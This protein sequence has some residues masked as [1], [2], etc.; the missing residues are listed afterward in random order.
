[1][2]YWMFIFDHQKWYDL[3]EKN[4]S[5]KTQ[6]E[7][8]AEGKPNLAIGLIYFL[9]GLVFELSYIPFMIAM[10]RKEFFQYSCYKFMFMMGIYDMFILPCNGI[11]TGIQVMKGEHFCHNPKL[12]YL[13]GV[14]GV[15]GFYG[16][17]TLCV[18]LGFDR[19]LEM[20]FPR[21][22]K[23][24]FGGYKTYLWMC[25]PIL[26]QGYVGFQLPHIFNIK[27]YAMHHDPYNLIHGMENNPL[28]N[29]QAFQT[30][31]AWNNSLIIAFLTFFYGGLLVITK[32]RTNMY[33][34]STISKAQK[35][36]S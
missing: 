29:F 32:M 2:G 26:Y 18:I 3:Y 13:T 35:Q 17:T 15:V 24:A 16:V 27:I 30:F 22:A 33:E 28:F 34:T 36:V 9:T 8:Y 20:G 19:F 11:I 6:D 25:I 7:W 5:L 21:L 1:M 14:T 4:C 10:V 23:Y 12:Y 31:F